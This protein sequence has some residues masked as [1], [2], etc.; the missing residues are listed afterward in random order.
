MAAKPKT[1]PERMTAPDTG[2]ALTRGVRP[3]EVAYKGESI[4]VELPGYYPA[5]QGEGVHV[6]NDMSVVDQA[7]R[8]LKEKIE[9]VPSPATIRRVR[10]KLKLS[11]REAGALLKVGEN[12]FYKYERGL[13]EPSGPT[14]QLIKVLDR[15]PEIADEL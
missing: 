10:S 11:Q 12:A 14:S 4:T 5:G 6:G 1:L 7:L 13:A 15:H 3:F 2:E 9:G 8:A